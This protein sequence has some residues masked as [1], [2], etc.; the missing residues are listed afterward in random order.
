[1]PETRQVTQKEGDVERTQNHAAHCSRTVT[2]DSLYCI[3]YQ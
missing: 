1:L 3:F 2:S